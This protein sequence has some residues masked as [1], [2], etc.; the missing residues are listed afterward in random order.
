MK[1]GHPATW[2]P[3]QIGVELFFVLSGFVI[4][5]SSAK[6]FNED[7]GWLVFL[8]RRLVRVV[9]IYWIATSLKIVA[10]LALPFM[11]DHVR[12]T[13]GTAIS[14]YLFLPSRDLNGDLYPILGVGWTLNCEMFFYALFTLSLFLRINVYRFVGLIL[15]AL[16][17]GSIL[18]QHSWPAP[19]FYLNSELLNFYFGMLIGRFCLKSRRLPKSVAIC[20][21]VFGGI[22]ILSFVPAHGWAEGLIK[23]IPCAL[24][25]WGVSSLEGKV[26]TRVPRIIYFLAD[27]SYA[28]YLFH[29]LIAQAPPTIMVKLHFN[30]PWISVLS[31]ITVSLVAGAIIHRFVELPITVWLRDRVRVRR[32]KIVHVEG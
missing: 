3:G 28:T 21:T 8:E 5:V 1:F 10:I 23:G 29:L 24:I 27:A 11:V 17:F 15:G 20:L 25:I 16:A 32:Q 7:V 19:A 26:L 6:L 12:L 14:S 22:F 31:S 30:H 18:R 13:W 9:P 4:V 2:E